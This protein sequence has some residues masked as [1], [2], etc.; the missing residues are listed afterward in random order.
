MALDNASSA[1]VSVLPCN[2]R[3]VLP[4][5]RCGSLFLVRRVRFTHDAVNIRRTRGLGSYGRQTVGNCPRK[6]RSGERGY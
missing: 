4:T 6:P 1:N 3:I 2:K 5:V